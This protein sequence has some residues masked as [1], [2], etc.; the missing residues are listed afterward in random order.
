VRKARGVLLLHGFSV[1]SLCRSVIDV[2]DFGAKY[3]YFI[4]VLLTAVVDTI[5]MNL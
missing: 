4:T 5:K 3:I 2:A 1:V